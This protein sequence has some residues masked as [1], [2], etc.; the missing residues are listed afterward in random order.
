MA[1]DSAG[2]WTEAISAFVVRHARAVIVIWI[3]LVALLLGEL[4]RRRNRQT[5]SFILV[6]EADGWTSARSAI[7][8]RVSKATSSGLSL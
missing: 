7:T 5:G 2:P 1:G 8:A 3:A 4:G 6:D